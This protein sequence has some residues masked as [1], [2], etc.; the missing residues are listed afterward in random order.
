MTSE[1]ARRPRVVIENPR[2]GALAAQAAALEAAGYDVT[3]CEGPDTHPCPVLDGQPCEYLEDADVVV[4][5]L[6][7]DDPQHRDVLTSVRERYPRLPVVVEA[8]THTARE[9]ARDLAPC[10][11]VVPYSMEHVSEAVSEA[12]ASTA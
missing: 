9:H 4:Y 12:L 3:T 11:V 10:T 2:G 6:D 7:L 5:D 1:T 8:T